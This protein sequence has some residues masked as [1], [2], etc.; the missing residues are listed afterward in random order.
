MINVQNLIADTSHL[1]PHTPNHRLETK[2][3]SETH[4]PIESL[5]T[6]H[7]IHRQ[8]TDLGGRLRRGPNLVGAH[9]TNVMKCEAQRDLAKKETT[10]LKVANDANQGRLGDGEEKIKKLKVQLNTAASNREY[11]GLKDQIAATETTNSALADKI[12]EG[13]ELIDESAEKIVEAEKIYGDTKAVFEKA[14]QKVQEEEPLITADIRRLEAELAEWENRLD[15]DFKNL[16]IRISRI[17]GENALSA[18]DGEYCTG[19]N[20]LVPLNNIANLMLE[21]PKPVVCEGCGRLL[22]VPEGWSQPK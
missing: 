6:L 21:R 16:Y 15:G 14:R 4:A 8:L 22:Y 9:E 19:C 5:R 1:K 2:M 18:I 11:Q 20:K 7:R 13:M 10:D 17:K 3:S 12:L